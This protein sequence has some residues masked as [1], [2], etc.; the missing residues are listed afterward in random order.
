[1]T[2]A[3]DY[4]SKAR[5]LDPENEKAMFI[6]GYLHAH[7]GEISLAIGEWEELGDKTQNPQIADVVR[8]RVEAAQEWEKVLQEY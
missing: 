4:L 2:D 8:K 7:L 3:L 5:E 6:K 1:M